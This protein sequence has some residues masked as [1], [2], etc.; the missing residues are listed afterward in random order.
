VPAT[1]LE[2]LLR[3]EE[4]GGTWEVVSDAGGMLVVDL[5][6]CTGGQSVGTIESDAADLRAHVIRR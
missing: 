6:P 3:W 4:S 2:Q 1:A 5:L